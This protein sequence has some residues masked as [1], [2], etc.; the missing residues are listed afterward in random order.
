MTDGWMDRP[1]AVAA[2]ERE[3]ESLGG[4]W[5][6]MGCCW[7]R[8]LTAKGDVCDVLCRYASSNVDEEGLQMYTCS[9]RHDYYN[10]AAT[11]F[12]TTGD[13]TIEHLLSR[14]T[15]YQVSSAARAGLG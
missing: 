9:S 7:P 11:L 6:G 3:K 2:G 13:K 12:F 1:H 10:P 15:H 5:Y 14:N 4:I 8:R